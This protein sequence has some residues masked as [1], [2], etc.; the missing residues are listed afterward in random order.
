MNHPEQPA[1][2]RVGD[3]RRREELPSRGDRYVSWLADVVVNDVVDL[4]VGEQP[5]KGE[6]R[7]AEGKAGD[8]KS[9]PGS[10]GEVLQALEADHEFLL[11]GGVFT[12]DVID[13]WIS[14]KRQHELEP[15]ALRPHP[16]EFFLYSD[17]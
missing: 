1:L 2:T 11:R 5:G 16:Y 17:A 15:V 14:Y 6:G 9:T 13:T 10:L 8:I 12:Q 7:T 3:V 4:F